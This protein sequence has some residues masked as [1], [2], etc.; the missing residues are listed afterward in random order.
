[1]TA[2]ESAIV[3]GFGGAAKIVEGPVA[4][5]APHAFAPLM[6]GDQLASPY[7][8]RC[9]GGLLHEIHATEENGS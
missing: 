5:V 6:A 8:L 2:F 4:P 9:G 7:C 3:D 1:M